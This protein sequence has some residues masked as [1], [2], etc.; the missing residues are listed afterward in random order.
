MRF[1]ALRGL[2]WFR[3]TS[4]VLTEPVPAK[5]RRGLGPRESIVRDSAEPPHLVRWVGDDRLLGVGA[6]AQTP[7]DR[8]RSKILVQRTG[9]LM[10]EL[11]TLYPDISGIA[12]E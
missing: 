11:S 3:P 10:Y 12:P 5:V 2:F 7:P 4:L 6:G 1:K 8:L 9:Q